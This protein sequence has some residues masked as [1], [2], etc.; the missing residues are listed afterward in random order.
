MFGLPLDLVLGHSSSDGY[1]FHLMG[2]LMAPLAHPRVADGIPNLGAFGD[3]AHTCPLT[4]CRLQ[5]SVLPSVVKL[6]YNFK[7]TEKDLRF[8]KKSM[9]KFDVLIY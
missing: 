5:V 6:F 7:K 3:C 9:S 1:G 8:H 4:F 2:P